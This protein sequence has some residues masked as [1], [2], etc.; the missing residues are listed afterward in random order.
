MQFILGHY[1]LPREPDMERAEKS[2]SSLCEVLVHKK[3]SRYTKE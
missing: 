2:T 1:E 3:K